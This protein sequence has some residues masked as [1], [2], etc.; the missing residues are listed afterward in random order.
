[1]PHEQEPLGYYRR[2]RTTIYAS[3][4][5]PRFGYCAYV[6]ESYDPDRAEPYRVLALIHST[7]RDAQYIR[8]EFSDLAERQDCLIFAPLFPAGIGD[9]E[10]VDN[11]KFLEYRGIRFD[12][13]FLD[14]LEEFASVYHANR[15]QLLMTGFS[16]GGHFTHRFLYTHPHRLAGVSIA[17]PGIVTLPDPAIRWPGGISDLEE[18]L[19]ITP[20][21]DAIRRVPVHLV[22]GDADTETWE[23]ATPPDDPCFVPG[24]NDESTTR[25]A[26][27]E[28]LLERLLSE[29]LSAELDRV[30]GAAHDGR[31]LAEPTKR[32][33]ER[34][35]RADPPAATGSADE[36]DR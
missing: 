6:P 3:R 4:T 21:L 19:G 18:V 28:V 27:L 8:D 26:K 25:I 1:M 36:A 32:F 2:G 7:D 11:Y 31:S 5:D 16:G 15:S 12:L 17:A 24:V 30:P 34:L 13:L 23:I 33:F 10:D 22:V 20:D 9:P 14:M 35:L 29:R